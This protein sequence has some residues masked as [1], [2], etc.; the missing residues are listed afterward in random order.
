[1]YKLSILTIIINRCDFTFKKGPMY[2][3]VQYVPGEKY[4]CS[5]NC[6]VVK[7]IL[8]KLYSYIYKTRISQYLGQRQKGITGA[9]ARYSII[10]VMIRET[11]VANKREGMSIMI[12]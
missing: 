9:H 2:C 7:V 6:I 3:T 4:F 12:T 5:N 10:R 1:M 8:L 11:K